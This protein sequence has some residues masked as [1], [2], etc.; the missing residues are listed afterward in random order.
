MDPRLARLREVRKQERYIA[1]ATRESFRAAVGERRAALTRSEAVVPPAPVSDGYAAVA[2]EHASASLG[3]AHGAA[4][5]ERHEIGQEAAA[6]A[7]SWREGRARAGP[8]CL[9]DRRAPW[10]VPLD[11]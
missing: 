6:E 11:S 10:H 8:K 3:I 9:A 2:F 7:A 1:A 4:R 5:A